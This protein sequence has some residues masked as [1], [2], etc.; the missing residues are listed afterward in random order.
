MPARE[1][2]EDIQSL[3]LADHF[4]K[5]PPVTGNRRRAVHTDMMKHA[6]NSKLVE[7]QRIESIVRVR[8][9]NRLA[10]NRNSPILDLRDTREITILHLV[11]ILIHPVLQHY[12]RVGESNLARC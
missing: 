8:A 12:P 5:L 10:E 1:F 7:H 4:L 6:L 2:D 9:P 3:A 11:A